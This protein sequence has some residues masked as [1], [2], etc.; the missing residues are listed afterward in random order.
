MKKILFLTCLVFN[1]SFSQEFSSV[2]AKISENLQTVES[3]QQEIVQ[4]ITE[5]QSGVIE[6]NQIFTKIK[7][8]SSTEE[9]HILNMMDIDV[10]TIRTITIK[11]VIYVQLLVVRKQNMIKQTIDKSKVQYKNEVKILAKNIDNGRDLVELFKSLVPISTQITETRLSLKSLDDYLSWLSTNVT[12]V[13]QVDGKIVQKLI[14]DKMPGRIEL[15]NDEIT[16]KKTTTKK[17]QLNLANLN[18]NSID[19]K[20][21]GEFVY[22]DIETRRKWKTIKVFKDNVQ[23]NY[24]ANLELYCE[25]V[26]TAR[27]VQKVLKEVIPL[28]EKALDGTIPKVASVNSGIAMLNK[29]I[30]TVNSQDVVIKQNIE[31]NCVGVFTKET[32][33]TKSN[34]KEQY[35]FNWGDINKNNIKYNTKGKLV[36][37]DLVTKGSEKYV[38]SSV[39]DEV[40]NYRKDFELNFNEV[41]EA[42]LAESIVYQIIEICEKEEFAAPKTDSEAINLL[43]RLIQKV[44]VGKTTYEQYFEKIDENLFKIKLIDVTS[45]TSKEKIYEFNMGDINAISVNFYTSSLNVMV[46]LKTNY[47]EKIIKYYENGEIKSYQNEIKLQGTDIENARQ[48]VTLFKKLTEKR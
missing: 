42:Y 5:K 47:S 1:L 30:N 36:Y 43:S 40:K 45:K 3:N 44:T 25:S 46:E 31:D 21:K 37:L 13:N 27:D 19:L 7:D 39:N 34:E 14:S 29:Y 10:N 24:T 48:I 32:A 35:Q 28:A 4:T 22:L 8:G 9:S 2:V 6:L 15:I 38:K 18:A 26:E 41:E 33:T 16:S 23:E 20:T 12:D 17:I 11:D